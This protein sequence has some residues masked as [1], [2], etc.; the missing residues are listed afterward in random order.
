VCEYKHSSF[1]ERSVSDEEKKLHN[2]DTR[3]LFGK[4]VKGSNVANIGRSRILTGQA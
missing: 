1:L 3:K 2:I 4:N